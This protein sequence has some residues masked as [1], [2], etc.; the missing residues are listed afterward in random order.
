MILHAKIW[1]SSK[2]LCTVTQLWALWVIHCDFIWLSQLSFRVSWKVS[3]VDVTTI[4]RSQLSGSLFVCS[5]C[6]FTKSTRQIL[7]S[8]PSSK[9]TQCKH[10]PQEARR[11]KY[12]PNYTSIATSFASLFCPPAITSDSP[13]VLYFCQSLFIKC[14]EELKAKR[15]AAAWIMKSARH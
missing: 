10:S 14:Q 3:G 7:Q 6:M 5:F 13:M 8:R 2:L 12:S 9:H 1:S 11:S 15:G 4:I